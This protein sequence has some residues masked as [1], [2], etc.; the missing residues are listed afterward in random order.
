MHAKS[1]GIT[2]PKFLAQAIRPLADRLGLATLPL[3]V[4]EIIFSYLLYE[5]IFRLAS[6]ALS[7]LLWPRKYA[8]FRR[9][10]RLNWDAH[11]VSMYQ[12]LFINAAALWCIF[13]DPA[14]AEHNEAGNWAER[15]W[16]YNGAAGMCQAFAAGYFVWDVVTSALHV[17]VMGAS[18]LVHAVAALGVTCI[19]FVSFFLFAYGKSLC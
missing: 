9:R 1:S 17:D 10:D 15:L 4:H 13:A 2:A 18:S 6:P 14:R 8:A 19:G 3:H 7:R 12:A 16:G 11:V 5:F